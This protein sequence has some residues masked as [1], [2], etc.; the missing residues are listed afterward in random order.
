MSTCYPAP[1]GG[2][3]P[4]AYLVGLPVTVTVADDGTVSYDVDTSEAGQAIRESG[5]SGHTDAQIDADADTVDR[6]VERAHFD[7]LREAAR[8]DVAAAIAGVEATTGA[9]AEDLML[10]SR[11]AGDGIESHIHRQACAGT[12][13]AK[14]LRGSS[15]WSLDRLPAGTIRRA[16]IAPCAAASVTR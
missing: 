13:G 9:H 10:V 11:P 1:E 15:G 3:G 6:A 16:I 2:A 8:V 5:T 4:R 7:A 14:I 12:C